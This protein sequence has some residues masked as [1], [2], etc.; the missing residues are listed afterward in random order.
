M[1]RSSTITTISSGLFRLTLAT[2][3]GGSSSLDL[4]GLD[5][6]APLGHAELDPLAG[7]QGG[8]ARGQ[9]R[10]VHEDLTPVVA[11]EK[12]EPFVGVIPFDLASG[13]GP[14]LMQ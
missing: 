1:I 14:D 5:A 12:A 4:E 10:G 2:V 9:R 7:P 8:A 3:G 13:H 11:G 6:P